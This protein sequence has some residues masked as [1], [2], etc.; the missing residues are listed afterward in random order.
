MIVYI[1]LIAWVLVSSLAPVNSVL[2]NRFVSYGILLS[3]IALLIASI[4]FNDF[5]KGDMPRYIDALTVMSNLSFLDSLRYFGW[6]PLFTFMQWIFAKVSLNGYLYIIYIAILYIFL[7]Y[8]ISKHL[9][10]SWQR[11]FFFFSYLSLTFFYDYL[12]NGTRQGFAMAFILLAV[13][14]WNN[15]NARRKKVKIVLSLIAAVLFHTS[16]LPV[17]LLILVLMLT[18]IKLNKLIFVWVFFSILFLTGLNSL[19]S[20]LPFLGGVE[21]LAVYNDNDLIR[22]FGEVNKGNFFVL[23]LL[24]IIVSLILYY[25]V[26]LEETKRTIYLNFIKVYIITNTLFLA[27]GFI[28]YSNRIATFSWIFIP[29]LIIYPVLHSKVNARY[30][31]FAMVL[32][33]AIIGFVTSAYD[34]FSL[35]LYK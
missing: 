24:I 18:K 7:Y 14:I 26:P 10:Y 35:N 12:F 28:A 20:E 21:Y 13:A 29:L 22:Q 4:P 33:I 15:N 31:L 5:Y 11:V 3:L 19:I 23:S 27:F 16:A 1:A 30:Y 25:K 6:E 8:L 17:V 32:A 34:I 9:F 2:K